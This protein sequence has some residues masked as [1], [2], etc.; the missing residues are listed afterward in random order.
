MRKDIKF[1]IAIPYVA[2]DSFFVVCTLKLAL[3]E[4]LTFYLSV[5]AG[6][7]LVNAFKRRKMDYSEYRKGNL[8]TLFQ[9]YKTQFRWKTR[10]YLNLS[11]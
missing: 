4:C 8:S 1:D 2:T 6:I 3:K 7:S 5:F 10:P 11:T 9:L